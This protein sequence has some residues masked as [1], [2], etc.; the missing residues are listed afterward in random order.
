MKGDSIVQLARF[1]KKRGQVSFHGNLSVRNG[2]IARSAVPLRNTESL[3]NYV[4]QTKGSTAKNNLSQVFANF[5]EANSPFWSAFR[6]G[7]QTAISA[8]ENNK[9]IKINLVDFSAKAPSPGELLV[10][11]LANHQVGFGGEFT[12]GVENKVQWPLPDPQ[13]VFTWNLTAEYVEKSV[14]F[15]CVVRF[16]RIRH[17]ILL[18]VILAAT[19]LALGSGLGLGTAIAVGQVISMQYNTSGNQAEVIK[20]LGSVYDGADQVIIESITFE[21]SRPDERSFKLSMT[22]LHAGSF[23]DSIF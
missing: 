22:I 12:L 1:L 3:R 23:L 14:I 15:S 21:I 16:D 20:A 9:A 6:S 4:Y 8:R 2:L 10:K 11:L 19:G 18:E 5:P 17:S 13:L 7:L